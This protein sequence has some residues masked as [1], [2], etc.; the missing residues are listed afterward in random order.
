MSQNQDEK[1]TKEQNPKMGFWAKLIDK[2]DR[3]MVE[4][5]NRSS[6]SSKQSKG[7]KCC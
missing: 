1:K 6:C 7:G 4:K 3:K 2:L 5:A